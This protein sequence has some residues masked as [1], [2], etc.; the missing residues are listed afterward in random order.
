MIGKNSAPS[1]EIIDTFL[2]IC[3]KNKKTFAVQIN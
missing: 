2:S 1:E 3:E